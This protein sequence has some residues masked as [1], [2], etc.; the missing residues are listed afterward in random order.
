MRDPS[1]NFGE[2]A[3]R[4]ETF[5]PSYPGEVFDFLLEHLSSGCTRAVDLGAGTGQATRKLAALF[6]R[7]TAVEPDARL[8]KEA[9]LPSHA[10]IVVQ[11]AEDASFEPA[12]VDAVVSATAFHWMNQPLICRRAAQWL[13]SGGVFFPFAYDAFEVDGAAG[14]LYRAEFAKWAAYR[15]RR[16]IDCYDYRRPLEDSGAFESVVP[17][18]FKSR[19]EIS[20]EAAAGLISTFSFARDYAR[21]NGGEAYFQT[22]KEKLKTLGETVSFVVPVIGALGVKA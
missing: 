21:D 10:E 4:Y 22:L 16:L 15:D 13:K 6:A 5:R 2:A 20:H 12:S 18:S 3:G 19:H 14:D 9:R 17:F 8:A 1:V 11:S 7:V